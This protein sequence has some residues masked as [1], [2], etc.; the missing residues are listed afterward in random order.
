MVR[1]ANHCGFHHCGFDPETR[2]LRAV[3]PTLADFAVKDPLSDL[4]IH[5]FNSSGTLF[6]RTMIGARLPTISLAGRPGR[7]FPLHPGS[8]DADYRNPATRGLYRPH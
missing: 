4:R 1:V 2:L 5:L 6:K 3:G 8:S 7:A